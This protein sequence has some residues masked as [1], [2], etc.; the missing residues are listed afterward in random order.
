MENV[1]QNRRFYKGEDIGYR[2]MT[3]SPD[4]TETMP[5]WSAERARHW[6]L[7]SPPA[8]PS[9]GE[10]VIYDELLTRYLASGAEGLLLGSTPELRLLAFQHDLQL[11]VFDINQTVFS[12][13]RPHQIPIDSETFIHGDWLRRDIREQFDFLLADG[14]IN[15]LAPAEQRLLIAKMANVLRTDG[16]ALVRVHLVCAPPF[17]SIEQVF[18][19]HR[20]GILQGEVFSATRTAIDMLLLEEQ[21]LKL[22]FKKLHAVLRELQKQGRISNSEFHAYEELAGFN[23]IAIHYLEQSALFSEL[24]PYF[25]IVEIREGGDYAFHQ[26]HPILVLRRI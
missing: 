16:L 3:E 14:S 25:K 24:A 15:M 21:S 4:K 18:E 7:F 8:R 6:H 13:L 9:R 26:Q 2:R 20:N 17:S 12:T 23:T 11:S 19:A 5:D 1:F 22:C 10:V